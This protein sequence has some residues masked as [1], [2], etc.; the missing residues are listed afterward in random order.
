MAK[1]PTVDAEGPVRV[2]LS[3]NGTD[4]SEKLQIISVTVHRAINKVPGMTLV[5][6]DGDMPQ[7]TF[8]VSDSADF[9]PGAQVVVRAGYGDNEADLFKGI[10]VRHGLT[11]S[12]ANDARLIVE[13]RDLAVKMTV[14][15]KSAVFADQ[16]DSAVMHGLIGNSG[17]AADVASTTLAHRG[18]VQHHCSDWDFLVTRADVNGHIV[19]VKDGAVKVGPP[20]ASSEPV[21]AITYGEDLQEFQADLDSPKPSGLT[22]LR[23]RMRFQGSALA[24]V[25]ARIE[26]KGVGERF[27]GMVFVTG[28]RQQIQDGD[29]ITEAE[30]GAPV[31]RLAER[32]DIQAPPD[33]GRAAGIE[34][35]HAGVVLN[36]QADPEGQ[37]RVQVSVPSAGIERVWARL[38]Q[39]HAS[40]SFG[41][42]FVP[43]AGD[44]VL[45]GWFDNDPDVPVVLGSLY[46]SKNMPPFSLES[47]NRTK[48]IV[49]RCKARLEFDDEDRVITLTTPGSNKLVFSDKD[50]SIVIEDQNGNKVELNSNGITL[51][52]PKDIRITAQGAITLEAMNAVTLKSRGDVS[53]EG[54]NVNCTAQAGFAAKGSATAE[55]SASGQTTVTGAI[56]M[57]N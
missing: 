1:S 5:L 29:W 8:P 55:L 20:D 25:G 42:F 22:R 4:L 6:A 17:L 45:L 2:T 11:I 14:D 19:V 57:I 51:D 44:E 50:Q 7:G 23:G 46:S 32:T 49:T 33:S 24:T 31:E 30:F 39:F 16:T 48:A 38:L 26:L 37:H 41:A 35:L 12:G 56:V 10:V 21:L 54:L 43:E 3:S 36:L 34:G 52:S 27:N 15:R 18:L 28:L 13:C 40:H 9:V 53:A 47:A